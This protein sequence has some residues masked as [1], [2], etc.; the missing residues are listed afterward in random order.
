MR[1][2]PHVRYFIA[3]MTCL[4]MLW[5]WQ[6]SNEASPHL[7]EKIEG[8]SIQPVVIYSQV[9]LVPTQK[10][11]RQPHNQAFRSTGGQNTTI[12][13]GPLQ[14]H[15]YTTSQ[16]HNSHWVFWK[17]NAHMH[18]VTCHLMRPVVLLD[19]VAFLKTELILVNSC[20]LGGSIISLH[21]YQECWP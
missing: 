18:S 2:F 21:M 5:S 17:L 9:C 12:P 3:E 4:W 1:K 6:S 13:L 14:I 20:V 19:F 8:F 7:Q 11:T 10:R 16:V 15:L